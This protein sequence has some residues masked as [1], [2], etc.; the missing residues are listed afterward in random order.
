MNRFHRN[1]LHLFLLV[2]SVVCLATSGCKSACEP[3]KVLKNGTCVSA[4][5]TSM[6]AA[7]APVAGANGM[8]AD[9]GPSGSD[10]PPSS[11]RAG[12]GGTPAGGAGGDRTSDSSNAGA[13]VA[14]VTD[15][16]GDSSEA[17]PADEPPA[18]PITAEGPCA[19]HGDENFCDDAVLHQCVGGA[20]ASPAT[21]CSSPMLCQAGAAAGAC[22][23]CI[24]GTFQCDGAALNQCTQD[25]RYELVS[26][27]ASAELCKEDAGACLEMQCV[28]GSVTCSSDGTTLKT[29]NED[30]SAFANEEACE[31]GCNATLK[32]CNVCVPS[33]KACV[34]NSLETCS[35]DGQTMTTN[36]CMPSGGECATS[37]CRNNACVPGVQRVGTECSAGKCD[38]TGRCV[39][40]I[41][42]QDCEDPGP[43]SN[44]ACTLGTCRPQPKAD[45]AACGTGMEC[46]G[47]GNCMEKPCGNGQVDPGESCDYMTMSGCTNACK[48]RNG[49]YAA[50][51]MAGSPCG[52]ASGAG[53]LCSPNGAC[54]QGCP[55]GDDDSCKTEAGDG[56]CMPFDGAGLN[57]AIVCTGRGATCP[58]GLKCGQWG[59]YWLCGTWE[60]VS[61]QPTPIP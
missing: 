24:P 35:A 26:E 10:D 3:G 14:S 7:E 55:D 1:S 22:G 15:A 6:N 61:D 58:G 19:G 39:A 41:T 5:V 32:A 34:G 44:R 16:G 20:E 25:G 27:C 13:A 36:E 43:C 33:S 52:A 18:E 40:C 45:G 56:A 57:C 60:L 38:A 29:C 12:S 23:V 46:D 49:A 53:W 42:A 8:V 54:T 48:W 51:S 9:S 21:T 28:P 59:P 4:F 47:S 37:T 30:G 50:C 31:A 11:A 17:S 2:S